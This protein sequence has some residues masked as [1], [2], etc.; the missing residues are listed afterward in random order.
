MAPKAVKKGVL[1]R[2]SASLSSQ[3]EVEIETDREFSKRCSDYTFSDLELN[4]MHA[5]CSVCGRLRSIR[6]LTFVVIQTNELE[7]ICMRCH[8]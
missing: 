6:D 2:P 8:G 7:K 1:K 5:Y 4:I 3:V